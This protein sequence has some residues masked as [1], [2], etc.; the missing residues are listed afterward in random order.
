MFHIFDVLDDKKHPQHDLLKEDLAQ[1]DAEE[2]EKFCDNHHI[3][4][5]IQSWEDKDLGRRAYYLIDYLQ[6][7]IAIER[8]KAML[9]TDERP[10]PY[11]SPNLKSTLIDKNHL[12]SLNE[13][14]PD[15]Y[16]LFLN[17]YAYLLTPSI[18]G[19][20][21]SYWV[22]DAIM[23][24]ASQ[25]NNDLDR[26]KVRLDPF[27]E[28]PLAEYRPMGYKM[29]IYGLPLNW[30]R[31]QNLKEEDH[32]QFMD[33]NNDTGKGRTDYVWK[34]IGHE[35]HFT[36]EELPTENACAYRGSRYFHAIFEKGSGKIIH[37][38]GAIRIYDL[39]ELGDRKQ[40]H[41]RRPE[42]RKVGKRIKIFQ[43]DT[44]L[45]QKDFSKL[46]SS[47]FV[48]NDDLYQYIQSGCDQISKL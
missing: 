45:S 32:G 18:R 33:E 25:G 47:F 1:I 14:E 20:N 11:D 30:E 24:I 8:I 26:F 21:S 7:Q 19:S 34:P 46:V 41:V 28:K 44:P 29:T 13:L 38:D 48:W 17:G 9:C 6:K 4:F 39:N 16:G 2:L 23:K 12:I 40:Y 31:L 5:H 22:F 3:A 27:I 35:L 43:I 42:A 15:G 37:C 10:K 36:C